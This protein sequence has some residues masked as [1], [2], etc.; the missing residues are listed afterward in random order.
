MKINIHTFG[1]SLQQRLFDGIDAF[2]GVAGHVYIRANFHGLWSQ[3][4]FDVRNEGLLN[5]YVN[6]NCIRINL[7]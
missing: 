3:S 1:L 7:I 2:V 5:P 4:S 6:I